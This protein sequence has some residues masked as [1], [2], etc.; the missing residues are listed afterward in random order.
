MLNFTA[1]LLRYKVH[2]IYNGFK[3]LF[4]ALMTDIIKF[5]IKL[6]F[7]FLFLFGTAKAQ[8]LSGAEL[9]EQS[10]GFFNTKLATFGLNYKKPKGYTEIFNWY[11]SAALGK[12]LLSSPDLQLIDQDSTTL[13]YIAILTL[14]TNDTNIKKARKWGLLKD[15]DKGYL[16][17]VNSYSDTIQNPVKHY[18]KEEAKQKF[19]ADAAGICEV[20]IWRRNEFKGRYD[21]CKALFLNKKNQCNIF[22]YYFY[23]N[24]RLEPIEKEIERTSPFITLK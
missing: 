17:F 8:E 24:S 16:A 6:L 19:N 18:T 4:F 11:Q 20:T 1:I 9:I 3:T 2:G 12:S 5:R 15:L 7:L 10:K 22:I 21:K 14:D 13:I 23:L